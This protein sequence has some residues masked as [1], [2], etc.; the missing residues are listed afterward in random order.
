[1]WVEDSDHTIWTLHDVITIVPP[2]LHGREPPRAWE[3]VRGEL[4]G[5]DRNKIAHDTRSGP[6]SCML[7]WIW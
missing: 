4:E 3:G 7:V 1:M 2:G 6:F 5:A